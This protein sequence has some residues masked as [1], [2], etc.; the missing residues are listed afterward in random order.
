MYCIVHNNEYEY[1]RYDRSVLQGGQKRGFHS[2]EDSVTDLSLL[3]PC[4]W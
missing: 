2:S 3:Y 1:L 4:L